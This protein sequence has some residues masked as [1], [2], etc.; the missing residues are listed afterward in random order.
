MNIKFLDH[1]FFGH[2]FFGLKILFDKN[3]IDSF[4]W[5]Q[6]FFLSDPNCFGPKMF[7]GLEMFLTKILFGQ[8]IILGPNCFCVHLPFDG[9]SIWSQCRCCKYNGNSTGR[10]KSKWLLLRSHPIKTYNTCQFTVFW[11]R[12]ISVVNTPS[13]FASNVQMSVNAKYLPIYEL[14]HSSRDR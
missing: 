14:C 13:V 2:T 5:I 4:Y 10:V 12:V 6:I 9:T 7:Y 8:K 1:S 3:F 11:N